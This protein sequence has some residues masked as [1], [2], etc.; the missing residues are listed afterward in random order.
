MILG[1]RTTF[2]LARIRRTV[3]GRTVRRTG[4]IVLARGVIIGVRT[5]CWSF[6]FLCSGVVWGGSFSCV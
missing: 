4:I 1:F 5:S 2:R 3:R 6:S